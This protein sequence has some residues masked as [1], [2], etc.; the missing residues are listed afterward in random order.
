MGN[1]YFPESKTPAEWRALAQG[2]DQAERESFER[3]DTDGYLSQ[4]AHTVTGRLY[5]LCA[6]VA[7]HGGKWTFQLLAD[8][9]GNVIEGAREV[10]T[11]YGWS[12]VT[13]QGHWFNPS[14]H[15]DDEKRRQANLR[16]GF[17]FVERELPAVVVMQADGG[18]WGCSPV[19]IIRESPID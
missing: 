4:W 10:K 2:S 15:S 7:E 8:V 12:W 14:H 1:V 3:S 16:K 13:P 5:R 11:R 17:Q 6:E 18:P 9:D 19:V